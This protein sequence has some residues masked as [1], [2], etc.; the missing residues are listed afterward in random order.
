[1]KPFFV[2][3]LAAL[4]GRESS[5]AREFVF[6]VNAGATDRAETPVRADVT[7]PAPPAATV[8]IKVTGP[9][10]TVPGQLVGDSSGDRDQI[11]WTVSIPKGQKG[12]YRAE[13]VAGPPAGDRFRFV[14]ESDK[15]LDLLFGD[16]PVT[17]FMYAF[18]PDPKQ[19]FMTAK[20][21]THVYDAAGQKIITSP[22][23]DPY[24]H[25]RGIFLGYSKVQP[26]GG[27]SNNFWGMRSAWQRT[28]KLE[29]QSQGPVLG[30]MAAWILWE[31]P[32]EKAV[33]REERVITVFRR[34][35]PELL[36]EF[37]STL[38]SQGGDVVLDGDPEH[39][40][41]QFRAHPDVA[42]NQKETR[43]LLPPGMK[44]GRKGTRDM[45]WAVMSFALSGSRFYVAQLNHPN[46]PAGTIFSAN[47]KYG[48]FGAFPK[49][50]VK[51]DKPL[52][53][54]YRFFVR[55]GETPL[56][57]EEAQRLHADFVS[58]PVVKQVKR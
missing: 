53:L 57:V 19:R 27:R 36:L 20:P 15:H 50:T 49:A 32:N 7:F 13:V 41:C 25:H 40:G 3:L 30:R 10:G 14:D 31:A 28:K 2:L 44:E 24:P 1:M 58:P 37:V 17:R 51:A 9:N 46:N 8:A 22:G 42:K 12:T 34:K 6:E 43:Y 38:T 16:R 35:P 56:T 21:F 33:L 55:E 11:W 39:A 45:P 23:G 18:D 54:R 4:I 5:V 52:T 29:L 26:A 47:R 48:R